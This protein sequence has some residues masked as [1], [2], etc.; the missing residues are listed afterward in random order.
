MSTTQAPRKLR[1]AELT[2][3]KASSRLNEEGK[4]NLLR[5]TDHCELKR[6]F[7]HENDFRNTKLKFQEI[8]ESGADKMNKEQVVKFYIEIGSDRGTDE[9]IANN[10][11]GIVDQDN[12]G[13]LNFSDFV[14]GTIFLRGASTE[15][16]YSLMFDIIDVSGDKCISYDEMKKFMDK[17]T[18]LDASARGEDVS[19]VDLKKVTSDIFSQYGVKEDEKLSKEQFIEG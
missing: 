11:F 2:A 14:L 8:D 17:L 12:D 18:K 10:V 7:F 19:E 13:L 3:L 9:R 16:E 4:T 1:D 6:C 15:H 5:M